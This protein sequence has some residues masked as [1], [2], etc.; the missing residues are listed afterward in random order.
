LTIP[1]VIRNVARAQGVDEDLA[2]AVAKQESGFNQSAVSARGAIGVMQLMPATA[3]GLGVNP[4]DLVGNIEGGVRYLRQNLDQFGG[5]V[6]K[7]LAA[8]DWGPGRVVKAVASWGA[9]WL[10]HAPDETQNYVAAIL[11]S[12]GGGALPTFRT[13][14]FAVSDSTVWV[15]LL[16]A[17][18]VYLVLED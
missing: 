13:T 5:A 6:D 16:V 7:A 11:P 3:A 2:L 12:A 1:D 4:Y 18:G 9:D 8:Y 10:A 17:L 14:V 15:W